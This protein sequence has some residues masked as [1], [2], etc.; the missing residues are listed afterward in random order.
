MAERSILGALLSSKSAQAR[1]LS[2]LTA[3]DFLI[4]EHQL[5]FTIATE[6][7]SKQTPIDLVTVSSLLKN[8]AALAVIVSCEWQDFA[9]HLGI[10]KDLARRRRALELINKT[11]DELSDRQ[12]DVDVAISNLIQALAQSASSAVVKQ[13][14]SLDAIM[15]MATKRIESKMSGEQET[16]GIPTGFSDFDSE[17]GGIQKGELMVIA[18]RPSEGK[19]ALLAT[20]AINAAKL[21]RTALIVNAEMELIEVGTRLLA[22]ESKVANIRLRRGQVEGNE[23]AAIT[24]AS[25]RLGKLPVYIYDDT[26]WDVITTQIRALKRTTPALAIVLID[27]IQR[28]KSEGTK[29]ERRYEMLGRITKDAKDLAGELGIAVVIAAQLNRNNERENTRPT[30]ISIRESGDIEQDADIVAFLH[31]FDKKNPN[32]VFLLIEKNRNGPKQDIPLRYVGDEVK[33]YDWDGF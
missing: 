15:I 7:F 30:L 29:E 20:I 8:R 26:R 17:I 21:G 5:I 6:F 19:S 4:K 22:G 9:F 32:K 25:G 14:L 2:E 13:P 10:V 3:E 12:A 18:A 23:I 11:R 24:S 16:T 28:I 27:Y 31:R 33:F 1:I